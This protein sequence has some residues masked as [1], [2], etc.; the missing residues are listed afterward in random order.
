M[1]TDIIRN[2]QEKSN[3]LIRAASISITYIVVGLSH[4]IVGSLIG[5]SEALYRPNRNYFNT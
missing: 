5:N 3:F 2:V 4:S 1:R